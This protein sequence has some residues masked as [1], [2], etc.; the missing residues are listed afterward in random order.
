MENFPRRY[1][2]DKCSPAELAI[3]NAINE[4]ESL[5]ADI[6]LTNI[7]TKLIETRELLAD[8]IDGVCKSPFQPQEKGT[9]NE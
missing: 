1:Q 7:V 4:V 6:E 5:G 3:Y 9:L 2:L 8:F